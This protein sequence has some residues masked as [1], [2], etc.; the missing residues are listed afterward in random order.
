MEEKNITYQFRLF[1][2]NYLEGHSA[3]REFK[4][5]APDTTQSYF[6]NKLHHAIMENQKIFIY[7]DYDVDGIAS[8]AML[9]DVITDF[10]A[11]LG[12]KAKVAHKIPARS[13]HYGIS[14]EYFEY[15]SAKNDLIITI[16]NGSH[17]SFYPLLTDEQ[18][19]KLLIFDHHPQGDFSDAPYVF[20]PNSDGSVGISSGLLIEYFFHLL[21][22]AFPDFMKKTEEDSYRDLAA[23]TLISDIANLN[24]KMVRHFI[25]SGLERIA[26]R[27]RAIYAKLLPEHRESISWEMM[28]FELI[29]MV[30]SIGRLS[31]DPSWAVDLLA[32]KKSNFKF[33]KMFA[34]AYVTNL[35]RKEIT[36]IFVKEFTDKIEEEN[37]L[38]RSK[39]ILF[40]HS[41]N[42]PI[43]V[44]GI[45]AS[46]IE[47]KYGVDTIV[48]SRDY[49]NDG[50]VTGSGRGKTV[51]SKLLKIKEAFPEA[52][53]H[54][55][56]GGHNQAVGVKITDYPKFMEYLGKFNQ[57]NKISLGENPLSNRTYFSKTPVSIAEYKQLCHEYG[58]IVGGDLGFKDTFYAVVKA[59]VVGKRDYR[60]NFMKLTLADENGET[61]SFLTVGSQTIEYDSLDEVLFDIS[62]AAVHDYKDVI[63]AQITAHIQPERT[64]TLKM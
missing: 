29:P 57:R 21:R 55:V 24:N 1:L 9:K 61:L 36:S 10:A 6:V 48:T 60:N 32:A 23:L 12:K 30:N 8:T 56:F 49:K 63:P 39:E 47:G 4:L 42:T 31:V 3:E 52:A 41:D 27:H 16:D 62:I 64:F 45:I 5:S 15:Y 18:K 13:D 28:A 40:L 44:N 14:M 46:S 58:N 22:N 25:K 2:K 11:S 33:K 53:Q 54:I 34:E 38:Q 43:G 59:T 51:K 35:Q 50:I 37:L 17:E 7:G 26:D 19:E 20:N